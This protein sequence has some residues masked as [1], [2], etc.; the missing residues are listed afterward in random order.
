M[1]L[2]IR[3]KLSLTQLLAEIA[4][5][6]L[7]VLF[8]KYG[9]SEHSVV[10]AAQGNRANAIRELAF[11]LTNEA[12]FALLAELV[13]TANTVRNSIS[14]RYR[15]DERWAELTSCLELDGYRV[16]GN[17]VV[18]IEPVIEGVVSVVDD[19]SAALTASGLAQSDDIQRVI[20]SS[21]NYFV[22]QDA[23]FNACLVSARVALQTLATAIAANAPGIAS[24]NHDRTSWGQTIAFLRTQG[25]IGPME[26]QGLT[27]VF[28]LISPGAHR[29][30]GLNEREFARL[31]RSLAISMTFFLVRRYNG[32]R[33]L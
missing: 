8:Q 25:L 26:E 33:A 17:T 22:R 5:D 23:D 30:I 18:N 31:G 2:S 20:D 3:T 14:P 19:L 15:F 10:Y 7:D 32:M 27:G 4:S 1:T 16:D 6:D 11:A 29:P 21:T 9:A 12:R 24:S 28:S 13:R